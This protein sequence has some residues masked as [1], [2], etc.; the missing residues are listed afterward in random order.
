MTENV[1]DRGAGSRVL[2]VKIIP[3][4][5]MG[6]DRKLLVTKLKQLDIVKIVNRKKPKMG[7]G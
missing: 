1:F 7:I 6:G 5:D 4:E 3:S 2:D